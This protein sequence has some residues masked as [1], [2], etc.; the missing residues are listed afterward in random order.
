MQ[1]ASADFPAM[2]ADRARL[3][4]QIDV[5]RRMGRRAGKPLLPPDGGI[6]PR[7]R[8]RA[9]AATGG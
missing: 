9:N 4:S 1:P 8:T 2:A 5:M 6:G 7:R 3:H